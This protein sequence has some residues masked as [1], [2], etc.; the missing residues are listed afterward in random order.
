M[1][2]YEFIRNLR[3]HAA[4]LPSHVRASTDRDQAGFATAAGI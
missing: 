1:V 2:S 4:I 3:V